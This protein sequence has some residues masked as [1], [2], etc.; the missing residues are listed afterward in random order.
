M[1]LVYNLHIRKYQAYK[2]PKLHRATSQK[3]I[4]NID[5]VKMNSPD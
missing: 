3:S 5:D 4:K 2:N 1:H